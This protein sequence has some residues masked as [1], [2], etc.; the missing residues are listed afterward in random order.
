MEREILTGEFADYSWRLVFQYDESY[1]CQLTC[2]QNGSPN[3][4]LEDCLLQAIG[5]AVKQYL[6]DDAPL[7]PS[8][9]GEGLTGDLALF[10][11]NDRELTEAELATCRGSLRDALT[12]FLE[13]HPDAKQEIVQKISEASSALAVISKINKMTAHR[14]NTLNFPEL[15]KSI[16]WRP[17]TPKHQQMQMDL[18]TVL[19][20]GEPARRILAASK[21]LQKNLQAVDD[22]QLMEDFNIDFDRA[23]EL[24]EEKLGLCNMAFALR[25]PDD[26]RISLSFIPSQR[27]RWYLELEV[28]ESPTD[29]LIAKVGRLSG[30]KRRTKGLWRISLGPINDMATFRKTAWPVYAKVYRALRKICLEFY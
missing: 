13:S 12:V 10:D 26:T 11:Q 6:P 9:V 19:R 30:L 28:A 15:P 25:T 8:V 7:P 5:D 17:S 4:A 24:F 23:M 1:R 20:S 18:S 29:A 27:G 16:R 3:D 22:I 2:N 14:K 21:R